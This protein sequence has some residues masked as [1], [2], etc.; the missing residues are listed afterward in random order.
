MKGRK[1]ETQPIKWSMAM[2]LLDTLR[3]KGQDN[4]RLMLACGFFFGLRIGDILRLRWKDILKDNFE[5]V[6]EKT[7]KTRTISID[8]KLKEIRDQIL[9]NSIIRPESLIFTFQRRDGDETKPISVVAA[10]KRIKKVFEEYDIKCKNPSSHTLRK[11][12]GLRIYEVY[13][14]C[15]DALVLLSQIFNHRDISI[16]RRY[17]GLTEQRIENAYLSLSSGKPSYL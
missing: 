10:N 13:N 3:D 11:T 14:R 4:T 5:I 2:M 15:E 12:F 9:A 1:T 16:T 8:P 7:G 17:I 6:E